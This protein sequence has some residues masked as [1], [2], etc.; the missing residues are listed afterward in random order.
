MMKK[1]DKYIFL[2]IS[3]GS[4]L[5]FFIFLSI[6]WLLQFT[7][8]ISLTN[9]I[10]VDI[11][12]ILYLSIFLIPNLITIIMP[13]VIMFGLIITF[14]KLRRD[15]ELVS[16]YSL[17]LSIKS[18]SR[19]LIFFSGIILS[20]LIIFNFY[21]SP[22][23]YKDYKIKE[24]EIR[25]K[26]D[27]EKIIISNFLEINQNTYLDFKKN[28][29]KFEE[30]FIKFSEKNENMIFAKEADIIQTDN[31]YIFNLINGF[32]I[33]L[34]ETGK[35]EK[36]EFDSYSLEIKNN[37]FQEYD[38][39]DKNTFNIFEDIKNKN[40]IN[41]FYKVTDSLIVILI[42]LFFYMNNIKSYKLNINS[43]LI[44]LSFSSVLLI[45][46]QILKNT[47]PGLYLYIFFITSLFLLSFIY[48]IFGIKNA[49]N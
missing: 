38:N 47:E 20:I 5:I 30:V 41:I 29:Q 13:F 12:T 19:P 9:L 44:F 23:I 22:K 16:I 46:N 3:K 26:V 2:E 33:T 21:L 37:S 32:K 45:I 27:F 42:I 34:L 4:L 6:S 28:N 36:L 48:F 1:I 10:Q 49:Q 43:L 31:K 24:Y 18:I 35:I 15:R 17:G 40:Y 25:N 7:R 8:L 11:I 39:F 14:V